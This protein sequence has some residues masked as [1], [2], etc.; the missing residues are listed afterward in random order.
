MKIIFRVSV[1]I[2]LI[3]SVVSYYSCK[4]GEV[5]ILTT[6]VV[7]NLT[8]T[9]A[10]S[11][12]TI[13][14]EGT[15]TV[16]GRGVCWSTGTTPT[17]ADNK[18]SDGAGAG[19]FTSSLSGLYGGT[20]YYIR[21]YA[22]NNIGTGYGMAMS[23]K[24][25]GDPPM[26]P[27]VTTQLATTVTTS[28]AILNGKVNAN[29]L[30][31]IVSFEYGKSISY[32]NSVTAIPSPVTGNSSVNVSTEI[33]GLLPG[34]TYHF[35]VKAQNALGTTIGNDLSFK[36][37]ET[38]RTS[39]ID[40]INSI[41]YLSTTYFVYGFSFSLA[42]KI[43]TSGNP[44]PDITVYVNTDNLPYRLTLQAQ[45]LNPSFYKVGDYAD[46]QTASAA[47]SSLK[48]VVVSQWKDMAD[49]IN[50]NQVWIYRSGTNKY[51]KIRIISTINEIRQGV[52]YGE[53]VIQW[54][55]Q[56]DGS[57]TFTSK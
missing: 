9:T 47:F 39:G 42:G 3:I 50:A 14:S 43:S 34:T 18:T 54:V 51:A 46:E 13:T 24:T 16:I 29:D 55:Y 31:S 52:Q 40:T 27:T 25:T 5:P 7:T 44:K 28:G 6:S 45:N 10:T 26:A 56:G 32:G 19:S 4:K 53:C 1:L 8:G 12:G 33:T 11:G 2:L 41:V 15:G 35:R 17:I 48:T 20:V 57:L 36:V 21:A 49:P 30:S 23:F 22:T 37:L 38:P